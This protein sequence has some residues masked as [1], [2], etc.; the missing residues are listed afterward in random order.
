LAIW[1]FG[2]LAIGRFGDWVIGRLGD[3]AIWRLGD[4][5][6]DFRFGMCDLMRHLGIIKNIFY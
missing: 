6:L 4:L 1:R 2:D 3:W 5:G